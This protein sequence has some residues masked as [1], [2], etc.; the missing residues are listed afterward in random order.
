M[1]YSF[2]KF[3]SG[4]M[5]GF[6][7]NVCPICGKE[8]YKWYKTIYCSNQCRAISLRKPYAN[9]TYA[10]KNWL[11][12][13]YVNQKLSS[14]QIS[15]LCNLSP[16]NIYQWLLKFNIPMRSMNEARH[17]GQQNHCNLT[18]KARQFID[19][20]L[21]GDGC[22]QSNNSYSAYFE[23]GSKYIE[24]A[25][26]IA[27]ILK[28]YRIELNGKGIYYR[29]QIRNGKECEM[30]VLNSR[31]YPELL[32]IKKRW[33]PKGKKIVPRDIKLTPLVCRQW[34]IGDGCLIR[35]KNSKPSINLATYSFPI[36]DVLF[37]I[38]KLKRIGIKA[39]RFGNNVIHISV[40]SVKD[41]LNYIGKCPVECYQ[42]KWEI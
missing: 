15:K 18:D 22:L 2:R 27:D 42:Y 9:K 17:L 10:N 1:E 16:R 29:K 12:N 30:F 28:S 13:K 38:K 34:Y 14:Y 40:Y 7:K 11:Q 24:Y 5:R 8:F 23:Y 36:N 41:F 35:P 39:T 21:L 31:C 33:Y 4:R 37:L 3:A 19:G 25:N 20:E 32:P 26:F 6:Y